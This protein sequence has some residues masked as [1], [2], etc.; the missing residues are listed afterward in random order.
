[1]V[2]QMNTEDSQRVRVRVRV[3]RKKRKF[4]KRYVLVGILLLLFVVVASGSA[5]TLVEYQVYSARYHNDLALAQTGIQHLRKAR[6]LLAGYA[7][8]FF[9]DR[10]VKQ[11][12]QEFA[13]ALPVFVRLNTDLKSLPGISTSIPVYGTHL[14]AA[15]HVLPIA[16]EISQAG[17]VACNTLDLLISRLHTPLSSQGG[18]TLAD[19]AVVKQNFEQIKAVFDLVVNQVSHLQSGDLQLDPSLSKLVAAFHNDL[20]M[21]QAWIGVAEQFFPV[22]PTLLGIGTPTNYLIE[23]LDSTELR[24]GGGFIGNYGIATLS[25]GLLVDARITDTNLLDRPFGYTSKLIPFPPAYTWFDLAPSWSFRD[26][27]LDADFPTAAQNGEQIYAQEG[28]KLPL[29]GTMAITPAFIEHALQ[30]TGPIYVTEY[31]ETVNAG[32]LVARIHFHQLGKAGEGSDVIPSPDGHS[33]QRK[34]FTALLAERFLARVRQL[35]ASALG[36]FS[37]L[38]VNSLRSKDLQVYFNASVAESILRSY[39]LDAAIQPTGSDSL[40]VVDANIAADKA[41]SFIINTLDDQVTIDTAGDVL[42]ST[43]LSYAWTEA[44]PIYGS[45]LY[46]DYVR[47]YV[48]PGS[49]LQMQDGWEPRGMSKAFSHEVWAGF[50]TLTYGQMRTI[51]LKWMVQNAAKKDTHG[52][53]YRYLIQ[54]QAG[55]QWKLSLRVA[56]PGCA[57]IGN[58]QGGLVASGKTVTLTQPLDKDTIVGVDYNC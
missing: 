31:H 19:F 10:S 18:L 55:T 21:L 46:R 4:P 11:A 29:E 38:L 15:F 2:D 6:S 12:Q 56:L 25:G 24:P 3:R 50:F 22:L 33:S 23:V 13:A 5:F 1:M 26:S 17:V 8:N 27:N 40:F 41:N 39:H 7:K 54:R 57:V 49:V 35:P 14:S 47:V 53:H 36:K 51:T 43:T 48:P 32:N 30:I 16:I 45:A 20:P 58:K 34:R 42:H 37:Q 28:G 44:G 9:D 52:W